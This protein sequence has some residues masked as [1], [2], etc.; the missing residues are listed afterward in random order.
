MRLF[1]SD[2]KVLSLPTLPIAIMP[3]EAKKYSPADRHEVTEAKDLA[4]GITWEVRRHQGTFYRY[5]KT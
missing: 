3:I 2:A 4:T 5:R 1:D